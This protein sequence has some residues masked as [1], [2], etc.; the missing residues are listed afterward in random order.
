V[1]GH[2]V[3]EKVSEVLIVDANDGHTFFRLDRSTTI[4]L[5]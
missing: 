3:E 1:P 5:H 2:K 4:S